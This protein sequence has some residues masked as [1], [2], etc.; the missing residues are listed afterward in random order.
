MAWVWRQA[1]AVARVVW[2]QASAVARVV[3][4]W[5]ARR[6]QGVRAEEWWIVERFLAAVQWRVTKVASNWALQLAMAW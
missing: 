1:S 6:R 5:V 2:R 4:R 3:W